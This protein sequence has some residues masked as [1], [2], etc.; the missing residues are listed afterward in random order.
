M[1]RKKIL[2]NL[3]LGFLF[4]AVCGTAYGLTP[5]IRDI[6]NHPRDFEGK[7]IT[8]YGT[9]TNAVSL[10]LIKY[11]EIQD[12]TGSIKVLTDKLLPG[13]GEKMRVTGTMAVVELGTERWVVI[14]ETDSGQTAGLPDPGPTYYFSD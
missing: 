12:E 5:K 4:L 14:R 2:T 3:I 7:Q 1:K 11:Y 9:V 13:R 8:I 10:V 6:L